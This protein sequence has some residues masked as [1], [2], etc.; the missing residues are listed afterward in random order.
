MKRNLIST[1]SPWTGIVEYRGD[2]KINAAT[3]HIDGNN[4]AASSI[5]SFRAYG[6]AIFAVTFDIRSQSTFKRSV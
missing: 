1:R 4:L 5:Y 3:F 2:I 6:R